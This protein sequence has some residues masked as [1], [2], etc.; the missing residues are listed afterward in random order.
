MEGGTSAVATVDFSSFITALSG[1]ITPVQLLTILGSFIGIGASFVLMWF[2][3]RKGIKI[4]RN[5]VFKG[6]VSG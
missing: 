4:F 1:I 3:V 6:K 2:G 5:A